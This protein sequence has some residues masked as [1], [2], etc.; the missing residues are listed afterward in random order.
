M[1]LKESAEKQVRKLSLIMLPSPIPKRALKETEHQNGDYDFNILVF[2]F[3]PFMIILFGLFKL[4]L[5]FINSPN[6]NSL[7]KGSFIIIRSFFL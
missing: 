2:V 1:S 3:K 4:L 5:P 6:R 7:K